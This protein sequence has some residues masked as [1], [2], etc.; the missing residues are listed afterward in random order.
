PTTRN[1]AEVA[2]R[3]YLAHG[4][5][6]LTRLDGHF[7]FAI[8]DEA[9]DTLVLGRD[10]FGEKP[11]F[12]AQDARDGLGAEGGANEA[13]FASTPSAL[14]ALCGMGAVT[15]DRRA[16]RRFA[17]F[18]FFDAT[19]SCL[20]LPMR[21]LA[22]A[23]I[24]AFGSVR[25]SLL[26]E[27]AP[28]LTTW[29]SDWREVVRERLRCD[30]PVGIFL[31]GGLDSALIASE[32]AALGAK[33]I[34]Y[35]LD[36]EDGK[37]EGAKAARIAAHLG[38]PHVRHRIG[39]EAIDALPQLVELYGL[40]LGDPS[41]LAVH[42]LALRAREDGVAVVLG[43]DG[44]DELFH[45]YRRM[46]A[47]PWLRRVSLLAPSGVRRL[48][49]ASEGASEGARARR[50]A[51]NR[52]YREL[53]SLAGREL[54]DRLFGDAGDDVGD[55]DAV[56]LAKGDAVSAEAVRELELT[57]YLANDLLVKTDVGGLAA[58]I[59]M[60]APY[61][62]ARVVDHAR[63]AKTHTTRR[64]KLPIRALLAERLPRE[65]VRGRKLG[66]GPPIGAWIR[67]RRA[68]LRPLVEAGAS[69]VDVDVALQVLDRGAD[70]EAQLVF[71][72][73]SLGAFARTWKQ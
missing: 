7:A 44:A 31:S 34:C 61:L 51:G 48:W 66:F 20:G 26:V 36:F 23:S 39:K 2:L 49:R 12:V 72:L 43:G 58:G 65:L 19:K 14:R 29:P 46:R 62:D 47:W 69:I 59:E 57:E 25:R 50:A 33:P 52:D 24:E 53:W 70:D 54:L 30:R 68:F 16:A 37:S 11:L 40:P 63:A 55:D 27:P 3:L 9:R 28:T 60:R 15:V 18:G 73:A 8:H 22:P 4:I 32:A 42:A 13:R 35:S 38:L 6:G 5:E 10:R 56:A 45:G 41:I 17:R 67:E 21:A 1:D 71:C 64:S